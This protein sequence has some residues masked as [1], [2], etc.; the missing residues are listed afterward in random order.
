MQRSAANE[1][2]RPL[3]L[4]EQRLSCYSEDGPKDVPLQEDTFDAALLAT[5]FLH[6][7]DS[8]D[9][10]K[11]EVYFQVVF[12]WILH[13]AIIT[14]QFMLVVFLFATVVEKAEDPYEKD[15]QSSINEVLGAIKSS[16]TLDKD[17]PT[18]KLCRRDH[19]LQFI[20]FCVVLIWCSRM[21]KE[22]RSAAEVAVVTIS[23]P[24]DRSGP[25]VKKDDNGKDYTIEHLPPGLKVLIVT[26]ICGTRFLVGAFLTFTTGKFL[27]LAGDMITIITKAISMQFIV[28]LD[29]LFFAAFIPLAFRQKLKHTKIISP[30]CHPSITMQWIGSVCYVLTALCMTLGLKFVIFR[31]VSSFRETCREYYTTFPEERHMIM[32]TVKAVAQALGGTL[33]LGAEM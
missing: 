18:M 8:S 14:F 26:L 9:R 11:G 24:H 32:D 16:T 33:N 29:E 28:T 15:L 4:E 2:Y 20:H 17:S 30:G 31:K 23:L 25:C 27:M 3:Q 21:L 6:A 13:I 5:C 10:N 7:M 12:A 22:L 19:T 1:T